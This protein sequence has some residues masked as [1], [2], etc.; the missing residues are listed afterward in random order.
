MESQD[1]PNPNPNPP[2]R[3]PYH[4]RS[5]S[6]VQ[7]RIPDDMDL[8]SDPISDPLFDGP[9][10]SEDDLFCSYMDMDKIGS[11]PTGDDPKHENANVSVG[12]RPRHRYSNSVDGTTSSSSVLESIE[13]KKA[14]DPDKLAE[15]WTVDPKRAKRWD[16]FF[17]QKCGTFTFI[18]WNL[19][20]AYKEKRELVTLLQNSIKVESFF[21]SPK[22]KKR[23]FHLKCVETADLSLRFVETHL[24][25][26]STL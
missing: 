12:A 1:P 15:L 5:Q 24:S 26:W 4:R 14:M 6:E 13:A 16:F 2:T 20:R 10:G 9:G 3:G 18:L 7:Y 21:F 25:M 22:E 19:Y 17:S 8:V 11:K 23:L